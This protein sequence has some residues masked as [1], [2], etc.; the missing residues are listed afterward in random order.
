MKFSHIFTALFVSQVVAS[1]KDISPRSD[2][3]ISCPGH[4]AAVNALRKHVEYPPHFCTYWLGTD[5]THSP[6][7]GQ[8]PSN[9]VRSCK[10]ILKAN[11]KPI[12]PVGSGIDY[13]AVAVPR[14]SYLTCLKRAEAVLITQFTYPKALCRFMETLDVSHRPIA[15][16]SVLQLMRGCK[17][18]FPAT[19]S[20]ASRTSSSSRSS[21]TMITTRATTQRPTTS[22]T[23][24]TT[25]STTTTT[26]STT[27]TTTT[28]AITTT[29]TT[30]TDS[31]TTTATTASDSTTTTAT[32]PST[33][34]PSATTTSVVMTTSTQMCPYI[35]SFTYSGKTVVQSTVTTGT[36]ITP[37]Y[38]YFQT[39]FASTSDYADAATKCAGYARGLVG[40][41]YNQELVVSLDTTSSPEYVCYA[42]E[43]T[44]GVGSQPVD[45]TD[46]IECS[47][48]FT[49]DA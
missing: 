14:L 49:Y 20:T 26:L 1:S 21:T 31:T 34:S 19:T 22:T 38:G 36:A 4:Q 47:Y 8:S 12:P 40:N 33:T 10:C 6:L 16:I 29:S 5:R 45:S 24:T 42:T 27:T 25:P 46:V 13:S 39:R 2:S 30:T 44:T 11:K 17:C 28:P 48:L 7:P 9:L 43:N 35:P 15:E 23:T 37:G 32:T 3:T 41:A 18:L